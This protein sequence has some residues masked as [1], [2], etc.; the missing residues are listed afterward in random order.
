MPRHLHWPIISAILAGICGIVMI[1]E[2]VFARA[3]HIAWAVTLGSIATVAAAIWICFVF[4]ARRATRSRLPLLLGPV[5]AGQ[6]FAGLTLLL[7]GMGAPHQLVNGAAGA[8]ILCVI[9]GSVLR[10]VLSGKTK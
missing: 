2:L 8:A 6:G 1:R 7:W 9:S 5:G 3:M 10:R 4:A